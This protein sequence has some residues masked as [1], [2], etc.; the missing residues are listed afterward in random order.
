MFDV[1]ESYVSLSRSEAGPTTKM[2]ER[3]GSHVLFDT[4]K[5]VDRWNV[6]IRHGFT[7][8]SSFRFSPPKQD[9]ES[10]AESFGTYHPYVILAYRNRE[11]D[12]WRPMHGGV[13]LTENALVAAVLHD[14]EQE[15]AVIN[16]ARRGFVLLEEEAKETES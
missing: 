10:N 11:S 2:L 8:V 4:P 1:P 14:P 6:R 7:H 13:K 12:R 3:Q 16:L 9:T 15:E 5:D